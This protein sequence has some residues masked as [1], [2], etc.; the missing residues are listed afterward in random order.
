MAAACLVAC[1]CAAYAEPAT[2]APPDRV[3]YK[4]VGD[5][6]LRL[7]IF[8][9]AGHTADQPKPAIVFFHGGA[10]NTGTP[11]AFYPQAR[12][13]AERG[14][15]A[16]SAEYRLK[17]KHKTTPYECVKDG[18]SAMRWVR[19]HAGELGVDPGRIA[20]AGGSA[21]GHVAAATATVTA[22]YLDEDEDQTV[23]FR[24]NALVLFNPVYNNGPNGWGHK[25]LGKR[26]RDIS[27]AHNLHK[28]MPPTLVMLGD[29]DKLVPV[30]VAEKFRD[31]MRELGVR[32]ELNIYPGK[33]HAF[34]NPGRSEDGYEL[35]LADTDAFLVS[36][37]YLTEP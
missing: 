37:R 28:D 16:I 34:F 5:V 27:P 24:P 18:I 17:N 26:W 9:P 23:S 11:S 3:V 36:L 6:T 22:G 7:H 19:A 1:A 15:V 14:M 12:H 2:P 8:K 20:A 29:K 33:E 25:R 30:P 31:D 10:W 13:L 35:T 21:G 4:T 32:S